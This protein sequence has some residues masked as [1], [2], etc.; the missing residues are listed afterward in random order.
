MVGM[1][2]VDDDVFDAVR[3]DAHLLDVCFDQVDEGLL[4]GVEHDVALRR[5]QDPRRH[6]AGTDMVEIVEDLEGLDLLD[7]D[8]AR[9][10]ADAADLL[11]RVVGRNLR[12]GASGRRSSGGAGRSSFSFRVLR[13]CRRSD[14]IGG[15][16][17]A[18]CQHP[19]FSHS[20]LPWPVPGA[21]EFLQL[22][23]LYRVAARYGKGA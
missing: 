15:H 23:P 11:E 16:E 18:R 4:R 3:V 22:Y 10:G 14:K 7:L 9:A 17:A 1:A 5:R 19:E 12:G 20:I 21:F 8:F 2:M 13:N 6:V